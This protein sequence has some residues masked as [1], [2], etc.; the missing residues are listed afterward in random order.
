[1][2]ATELYAVGSTVS[3]DE[4]VTWEIPLDKRELEYGGATHLIMEAGQSGVIR[5]F[6]VRGGVTVVTLRLPC[7]AVCEVETTH[8][9]ASG[10]VA[11]KAKAAA[12]RRFKQLAAVEEAAHRR[13]EGEEAR[14]LA[15][16]PAAAIREAYA[17]E[18][19]AAASQQ[20]QG[21][22]KAA[23]WK[24]KRLFGDATNTAPKHA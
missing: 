14:R 24:R 9:V 12:E 11:A 1:M 10:A 17:R 15:A 5:A 19:A 18:Q 22:A 16:A 4:E 20:P 6:G 8:L 23:S 2:P 13:R 7:G 3:F 21:A